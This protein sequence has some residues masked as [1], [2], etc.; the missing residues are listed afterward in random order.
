[1]Y[2]VI[3]YF[4]N[5]KFVYIMEFIKEKEVDLFQ[6]SSDFRIL[7]FVNLCLTFWGTRNLLFQTLFY[8]KKKEK[9]VKNPANITFLDR[10]ALTNFSNTQALKVRSGVRQAYNSW[11]FFSKHCQCASNSFPQFS[12][13]LVILYNIY[14]FFLVTCI[15]VT[16]THTHK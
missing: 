9:H 2:N 4:F 14:I 13:S 15:S 1:M 11:L 6:V 16:H 7:L 5:V 10:P 3:F 12:L 8:L